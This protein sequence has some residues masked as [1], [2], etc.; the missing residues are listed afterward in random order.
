MTGLNI[1][2]NGV[3]V[4]QHGRVL[5][6]RRDDFLIWA[7]PGG[8]LEAGESPT[9]GVVREVEEETGLKV[10]AISLSGLYY[11]SLVKS[12]QLIMVFKCEVV[13]GELATSEE[14]LQV[15]YKPAGS[16]PRLMLSL[17]R[18]RIR[19][20]LAQDDSS[21][22]WQRQRSS[23]WH[24]LAWMTIGRLIY[25]WKDWRR[26]MSNRPPY[27]PPEPWGTGAFTIIQNDRLL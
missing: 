6:I 14:S 20:A 18:E 5:L 8:G 22:R 27:N 16:L 12:P 24:L 17:H 2:T 9:D 1:I 7:L 11:W 13:G 23:P 3:V 4:D 21:S 19:T 26:K 25:G 15:A 10:A